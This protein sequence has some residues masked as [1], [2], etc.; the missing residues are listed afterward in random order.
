MFKKIAIQSPD[1]AAH[2]T[3]RRD[4]QHLGLKAWAQKRIAFLGPTPGLATGYRRGRSQ[5]K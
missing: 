5:P 2:G 1:L 4:G 3:N